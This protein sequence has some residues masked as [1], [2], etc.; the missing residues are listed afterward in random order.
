MIF[1][2]GLLDL[3]AGLATLLTINLGVFTEFTTMTLL[4]LL[5][6]GSWCAFTGKKYVPIFL[7]GALDMATAIT[8]LLFINYGLFYG[9]SYFLVFIVLFKGIWTTFSTLF[10]PMTA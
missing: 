5:L 4:L 3:I 9:I 6:K 7:L 1:F 8:C 10:N 2:L